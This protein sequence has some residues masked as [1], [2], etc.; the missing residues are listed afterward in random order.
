M[1][2]AALVGASV[3]LVHAALQHL[4]AAA[5][6]LD[7]R[8]GVPGAA[9]GLVPL[10]GEGAAPRAA[11]ALAQVMPDC[12]V[13]VELVPG[14]ELRVGDAVVVGYGKFQR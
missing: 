4:A 3:H 7:G 14:Q 2:A 5:A 9:L 11:R 8:V 10:L 6:F 12:L 13:A 1:D